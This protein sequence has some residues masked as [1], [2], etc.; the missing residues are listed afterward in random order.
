MKASHFPSGLTLE[1][2]A[3]QVWS[4]GI[5][6]IRTRSCDPSSFSFHRSRGG[7][8]GNPVSHADSRQM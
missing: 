2:V 4:V 8:Q 7:Y 3:F 1:L 5:D 6:V